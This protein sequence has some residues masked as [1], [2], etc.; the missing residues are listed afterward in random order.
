[1]FVGGLTPEWE[2]EGSFCFFPYESTFIAWDEGFDRSAL[3]MP[4]RQDELIRELGRA[5]R[6]TV[7]VLQTVG[8]TPLIGSAIANL[9]TG[10][11]RIDA[12]G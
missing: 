7:V 4:G 8:R 10:I 3:D 1:M 6:N 2:S 12:L 9:D 11:R 5:N